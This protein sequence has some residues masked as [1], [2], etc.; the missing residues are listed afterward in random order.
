MRQPP[1]L[2]HEEALLNPT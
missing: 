1:C 2:T